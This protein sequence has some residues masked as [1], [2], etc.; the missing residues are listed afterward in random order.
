MRATIEPVTAGSVEAAVTLLEAQLHEHD[1]ATPATLLRAVVER[2]CSSANE[3][4]MFLAR[5][6]DAV[7]PIGI[8]FAAAHLSAEHGGTVGWL[9][10]LYV[11]PDQRGCGAGSALL[12]AVISHAQE[13]QWRAVELEVVAGHERVAA[14]YERHQFTNAHRT[15]FTRTLAADQP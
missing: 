2:V 8:A 12:R 7:E 9:E 6:P 5:V 10:E 15:R 11:K 14:L 3:G 4:V 1:L 13:Q